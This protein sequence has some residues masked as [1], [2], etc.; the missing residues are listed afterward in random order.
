MKTERFLKRL[1]VAGKPGDVLHI[2]IHCDIPF[3]NSAI[4]YEGNEKYAEA[5]AN[6]HGWT[7]GRTGK[8]RCKKCT[9]ELQRLVGRAIG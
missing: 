7:I 8:V 6:S 3:C 9:E 1:D 2:R 4:E 5:K